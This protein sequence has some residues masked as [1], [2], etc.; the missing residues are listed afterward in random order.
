MRRW[1]S[2]LG[3]TRKRRQTPSRRGQ[4]KTPAVSDWRATF[5]AIGWICAAAEPTG[6]P[7]YPQPPT[8]IQFRREFLDRSQQFADAINVY[9]RL[10]LCHGRLRSNQARISV[11]NRA[12][13]IQNLIGKLN[14]TVAQLFQ[15]GNR[16]RIVLNE[17][18]MRQIG[19]QLNAG[20][21][22]WRRK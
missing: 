14:A 20:G 15:I 21:N 12:L 5:F 1:L 18:S 17:S 7:L 8:F 11:Y 22:N 9:L 4:R 13:D 3:P 19:R 10:S 2:I 6:G 16:R